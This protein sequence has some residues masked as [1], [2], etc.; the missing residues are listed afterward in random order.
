MVNA[1]PAPG[2]HAQSVSDTGRSF[3]V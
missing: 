1:K 2:K 3:I